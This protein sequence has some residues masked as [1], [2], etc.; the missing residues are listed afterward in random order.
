MPGAGVATPA[1]VLGALAAASVA[2]AWLPA[3]RAL[4]IRP[5]EALASE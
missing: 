2:A 5:S 4:G 1:I 3:R